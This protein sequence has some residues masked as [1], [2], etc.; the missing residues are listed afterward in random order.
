LNDLL[1]LSGTAAL[2]GLIHTAIGPDHYLP[3]IVM[4]KTWRWS[5]TK[6]AVIT[7]L[8]GAGHILSSVVLGFAGIALGIAVFK[9]EAVEKFRGDFA[10]WILI[11]FGFTY[12]VWGLH[13]AYR[14]KTHEHA[15]EHDNQAP[16]THTHN[17]LSGH[18]HVHAAKAQN[19]TPWILFTIFV[20]GPCEPLIPL[21]MYPAAKSSVSGVVIVT[22]VFGLVTITTMMTIVLLS[23][24]GLSRLSTEKL[25]RY[26][27]ASAGLAVLLCGLAIKF[28]PL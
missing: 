5:F 19:M 8:C 4:S 21:V 27:H 13:K 28:L 15:H 26:S 1:I 3:F 17:H 6:T 23:H 10:A 12:L 7:F 25:G 2:I 16:H 20:F 18:A 11:A 9:L 14:S 22:A 24:M